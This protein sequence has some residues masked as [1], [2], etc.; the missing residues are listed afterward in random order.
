MICTCIIADLSF[1]PL[2][3]CTLPCRDW[4][5]AS[6]VTYVDDA[7]TYQQLSW[8]LSAL[9]ASGSRIVLAHEHRSRHISAVLASWD[10]DDAFLQL[11]RECAGRL[12]LQ[13][14]HLVGE[15]PRSSVQGIFRL[16]TPDISLFE[17]SY[18]SFSNDYVQIKIV[19]LETGPCPSFLTSDEFAVMC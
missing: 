6:D 18:S 2:T 11:F 5:I 3:C 8:T 15:R 16:W 13:L 10:Q 12:G 14:Y 17:V 9:A 4:V 7:E 1:E 19:S